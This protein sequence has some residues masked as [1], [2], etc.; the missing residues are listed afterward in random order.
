MQDP[1]IAKNSPSGHHRTSLSGYIFATKA[2]I[3][4]RKKL[5]K[6][7][8]LPHMFSQYGELQPTSSWDRFVSL[9]TSANFNGFCVVASSWALAHIVVV[10]VLYCVCTVYI[11]M[12]LLEKTVWTPLS[13]HPVCWGS[14]CGKVKKDGWL[15]LLFIVH[16][17]LE[18]SCLWQQRCY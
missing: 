13:P 12:C 6:Q 16:R 17:T 11:F 7:Q 14:G 18:W 15:F 3:D 4:N 5:V 2:C 8:C 10:C 9:G 1:K